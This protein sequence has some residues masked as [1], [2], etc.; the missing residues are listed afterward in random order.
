MLLLR[1]LLA[2]KITSPHIE[3]LLFARYLAAI[4]NQQAT[5]FFTP[6]AIG[7]KVGKPA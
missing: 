5:P 1:A 3:T 7:E 6:K 2:N 4:S